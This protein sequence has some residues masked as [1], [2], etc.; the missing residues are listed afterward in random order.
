MASDFAP[1]WAMA[2]DTIRR[3]GGLLFKPGGAFKCVPWGGFAE[4]VR[5]SGQDLPRRRGLPNSARVQNFTSRPLRDGR[6]LRFISP[7]PPTLSGARLPSHE[8][9]M[10]IF[11]LAARRRG[12]DPLPR[13]LSRGADRGAGAVLSRLVVVVRALS[14]D[15]FRADC[16]SVRAVRRQA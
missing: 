11:R 7:E 12:D 1:G 15:D 16:V 13:S 6:V 8:T 2:P 14:E 9:I 5:N 10:A 3:T 4:H